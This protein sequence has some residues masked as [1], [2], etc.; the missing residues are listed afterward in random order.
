MN[1]LYLGDC[2]SS[3]GLAPAPRRECFASQHHIQ[4]RTVEGKEEEEEA[5]PNEISCLKNYFI[6][7]TCFIKYSLNLPLSNL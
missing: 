3:S 2:L 7:K 1:T 5:E 6:K 4:S